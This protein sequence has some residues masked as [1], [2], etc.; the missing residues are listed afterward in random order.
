MLNKLT[1]VKSKTNY[2][3]I[4]KNSE[5]YFRTTCDCEKCN[6]MEVTSRDITFHKNWFISYSTLD[7]ETLGILHH[8]YEGIK[9]CFTDK[10]NIIELETIEQ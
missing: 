8:K 6:F 1:K 2:L 10:T 3:I 5:L 4:K 7:N 9:C